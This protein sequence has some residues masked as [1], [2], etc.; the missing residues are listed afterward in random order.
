MGECSPRASRADLYLLGQ[1]KLPPGGALRL[2][3]RLAEEVGVLGFCSAVW[4]FA[5][6]GNNLGNAGRLG[7][8]ASTHSESGLRNQLVDD[9][10]VPWGLGCS[11]SM[12][13][14][15]C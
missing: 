8:V 9:E 10:M 2:A 13:E 14:G 11:V 3:G 6:W 7:L 5:A 1:Q 15:P 4:Q 12:L